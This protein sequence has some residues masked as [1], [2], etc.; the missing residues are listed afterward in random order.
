V[1][2]G[3]DFGTTHT[4]VAYCDRGNY[5]LVGFSDAQGDAFDWLPSLAAHHRGDLQFGFAAEALES[6][7]GATV[8]R[9]IKR[10]L[11][12]PYPEPISVGG[13]AFT[14]AELVAR[15]LHELRALLRLNLAISPN[16][17]M[18][19]AIAVPANTH[20]AQRFATLNAFRAAGF[21]VL[22]MLNEPS[23]AGFEYTHRHRNTLTAR[24]EHVVVYDLG[25]G[26]FDVSLVRMH[27]K[28]HE[29]LSTA[30]TSDLGGDDFDAILL[31]MLSAKIGLYAADLPALLRASL[32]LRCRQAKERLT[33][34]SRKIVLE[35]PEL[36][37]DEVV[38]SVADYFEAC[39]P[40]VDK[41]LETL[42]SVLGSVSD[43]ELAGIYVVG[44]ASALPCIARALRERYGR[45][46]HRSPYP[47]ASCA[48]G[49]AI[50]ADA[51]SEY[52]LHDRFSR[53]LGV[54]R[55][56]RAG[57]DIAFDVILDKETA[58][59]G[60]LDATRVYRAAHNVGHFRFVECSDVSHDGTPRG[61]ITPYADVLFPFDRKLQHNR[62]DLLRAPIERMPG[63][64]LIEEHYHVDAHGAVSVRLR[65]VESG[66]ERAFH[67]DAKA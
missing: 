51:D 1:R 57:H 63:G 64:P 13:S 60:V 65:D 10:L 12:D 43:A 61:D 3:I 49:L 56:A 33:P 14:P 44:G 46:V 41:T 52:Q 50:A 11:R 45:R 59:P 23:A 26:T 42:G 35:A 38:L 67:L 19:A 2:L 40:L 37:R 47:F 32:L 29:I 4:V 34:S 28:R 7:P 24:R 27:G 18:Q 48:I 5:P 66:F 39:Q 36:R 8:L 25:G 9:S 15:F 16:E 54:F 17:P 30:G 55:E 6:A 21:E 31:D 22:A 58:L 53:H 20:S 62:A